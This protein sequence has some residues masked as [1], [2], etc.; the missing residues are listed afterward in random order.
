MWGKISAGLGVGL[1]TLVLGCSPVPAGLDDT[2]F[3]NALGF[4]GA[5]SETVSLTHN[6]DANAQLPADDAASLIALLFAAKYINVVPNAGAAP[7]F[8]FGGVGAHMV[9]ANSNMVI[10]LGTRQIV[11][12]SNQKS[13][14]EGAVKFFAETVTYTVQG[15]ADNPVLKGESVGPYTMRL[16]LQNDPAVGQWQVNV[17]RGTSFAPDQDSKALLQKVLE[18]GAADLADLNT[19]IGKTRVGVFDGI[20]KSLRDSG[21]IEKTADPGVVLSP[22]AKLAFYISPVD[23]S[24]H[25][26]AEI[27]PYCASV[28]AGKYHWRWPVLNE[29]RQVV[30]QDGFLIDTPDHRI[31][32]QITTSIPQYMTYEVPLNSFLDN[33]GSLF[34]L[35][36]LNGG[37]GTYT[38]NMQALNIPSV[39]TG[40]LASY[41]TDIHDTAQ[42]EIPG[43]PR[44]VC[45]A[46]AH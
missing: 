43:I 41:M 1:L 6:L 14:S 29:L 22:N 45:V 34:N 35:D 16:V 42:Q 37:P 5:I 2:P 28:A 23:F 11:S 25:K 38:Y 10:P 12:R 4:G 17:D 3:L 26:L 9:D 31:W 33:D 44:I 18:I 46:D 40:G 15:A 30:G 24:H 13:W 32:G 39:G 36:N 21:A 19:T 7:Y 8:F 27:G 20:E